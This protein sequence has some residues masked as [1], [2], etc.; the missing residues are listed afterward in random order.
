MRCSYVGIP[1]SVWVRA[2]LVQLKRSA[3][4]RMNTADRRWA[5][6]LAWGSRLLQPATCANVHTNKAAVI[7][8]ARL[9]FMVSVATSEIP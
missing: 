7:G 1:L 2:S 9:G 3:A 8:A 6:R 4:K 5:A